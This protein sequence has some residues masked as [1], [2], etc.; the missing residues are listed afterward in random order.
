MGKTLAS[1]RNGRVIRQRWG[2]G[3]GR[4][5]GAKINPKTRQRVLERD[6]YQCVLCGANRLE[7]LTMDHRLPKSK[8]GTNDYEN[9]QTMCETCNSLKA[10]SFEED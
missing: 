9:L 1:A 2:R 4:S 3:A 10:N 7:A 5:R 6:G 8:G